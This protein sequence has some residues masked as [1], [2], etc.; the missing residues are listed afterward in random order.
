MNFTNIYYIPCPNVLVKITWHE[1]KEIP[2]HSATSLIV[3]DLLSPNH[4]IMLSMH[5]VCLTKCS[6]MIIT[7][8]GSVPIFK[9]AEP[10]KNLCT[11]HGLLV[12]SSF[13]HFVLLVPVFLNFTQKFSC[14]HCSVLLGMTNTTRDTYTA[15]YL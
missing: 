8:Y 5:Y 7:F 3:F 10:I 14:R 2:S 15:L 4:T 13:I 12:K 11:A 9:E 1:P 6:R